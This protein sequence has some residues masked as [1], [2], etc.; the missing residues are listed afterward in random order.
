MVAD[1]GVE[2]SRVSGLL[3]LLVDDNAVLMKSFLLFL[4]RCFVRSSDSY[5]NAENDEVWRS[6]LAE[7]AINA[8]EARS[9][10]E[11]SGSF[12]ESEVFRRI[13]LEARLRRGIRLAVPGSNSIDEPKLGDAGELASDVGKSRSPSSNVGG[14][15]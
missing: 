15:L 2:K 4:P 10:P 7:L 14:G 1:I 3:Q 11:S 13:A 9:A 5:D 12:L 8:G 6:S